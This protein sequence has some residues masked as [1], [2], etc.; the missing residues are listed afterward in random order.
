MQR[1]GKL[2]GL[3]HTRKGLALQAFEKTAQNEEG[4]SIVRV[5]FDLT[6]LNR[7]YGLV[8]DSPGDLSRSLTNETTY[9]LET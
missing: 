2:K 8:A 7:C 3:G 1:E 5:G 4:Q 9:T 6:I